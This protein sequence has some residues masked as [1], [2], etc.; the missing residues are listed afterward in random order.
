MQEALT[1]IYSIYDL[2]IDFIFNQA[3]IVE[4]VS[5]GWILVSIIVFGILIRGFLVVPRGIAVAGVS[6]VERS[7][8]KRAK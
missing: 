4:G 3:I 5:F 1:W 7:K 8:W 6:E 2:F